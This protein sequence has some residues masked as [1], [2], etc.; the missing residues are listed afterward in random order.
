MPSQ[1]R[2]AVAP[3]LFQ[4]PLSSPPMQRPPPSPS[5]LA[6]TPLFQHLP[7]FLPAP[8]PTSRSVLWSAYVRSPYSHAIPHVLAVRDGRGGIECRLLCVSRRVLR[9]RCRGCHAH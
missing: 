8:S 6:P 3:L 4:P 2:R 1:L 7:S 9:P 5:V